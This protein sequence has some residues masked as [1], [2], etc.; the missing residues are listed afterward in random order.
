[1]TNKQEKLLSHG[2]DKNLTNAV[3][4]IHNRLVKEG[5]KSYVTLTEELR[6]LEELQK[7]EL[8]RFLIL[9]RGLNGYWTHYILTYPQRKH[10][11]MI[12]LTD[13]ERKVLEELPVILATQQRFLIFQKQ[14]ALSLQENI[15][16]A[17]IPCGLMGEFLLQDYSKTTD[18]T[19][20]GI[21]LDKDALQEAEK[22]AKEKHLHEKVKFLQRDAWHLFI[23]SQFN[24]VSSNGLNIYE[25]DDDKVV[26]LY[27]Q[28]YQSLLPEGKLIISFLTPPPAINE[29]SEW[30]IQKIDSAALRLQKIIFSDILNAKWQCYR[31]SDLT[32][33]Q[34]QQA[35]FKQ[36]EFIFDDAHIFP[37]VIAKK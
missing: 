3:M 19:L 9:N 8:G 2:A 24:L 6:L 7:F 33:K 18:F 31:S 12:S 27:A 23:E 10:S 17:S 28:F 34:L 25:P 4:E 29:N 30:Q 37:T 16:M 15:V 26:Q 21:D 11:N 36:I 5:D 1:M 35:G 14:I 13:L 20:V 22:L 32:K